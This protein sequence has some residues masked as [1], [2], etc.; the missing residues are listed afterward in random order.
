MKNLLLSATLILSCSSM[1]AQAPAVVPS[2]VHTNSIGFSYILPADWEVV[3]MQASYPAIRDKVVKEADNP[4]EKLGASCS[5]PAITAR[6][7][8]PVSILIVMVVP[9]SCIGMEIS[10][11]DLPEFGSGV[12]TGLKKS[13]DL[14]PDSV[15][16]LYSLGTHSLWIERTKGALKSNPGMKY[17]V[18]TACSN[19]KKGAVCWM[20]M[21]ADDATLGVIEHGAVTLE[22]D[23]AAALVPANA[24]A[25]KP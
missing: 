24:F 1:L 3:D 11:K 2:Q 9:F 19:L 14:S 18:E 20:V 4:D 7:G 6:H 23:A 22:S 17:T 12:S 15:R 13:F 10:T 5:Q 16:G 8:N 21:A 25:I